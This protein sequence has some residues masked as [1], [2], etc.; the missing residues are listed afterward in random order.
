[1]VCPSGTV[2][3]SSAAG[4]RGPGGLSPR[5]PY[6]SRTPGAA[7]PSTPLPRGS[8]PWTP[9][10]QTPEGLVLLLLGVVR[11]DRGQLARRLV[12][13]QHVDTALVALVARERRREEGLDELRHVLRGVHASAHRDDVG[14]VVLTA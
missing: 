9:A 2:A 3:P 13:G 12:V 7:A 1:M 6:P 10:P 14:V 5:R 8:T 4:R 11:R